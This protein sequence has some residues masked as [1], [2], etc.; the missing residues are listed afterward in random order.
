MFKYREEASL[1]HSLEA[2]SLRRG[3]NPLGY[4]EGREDQAGNM[5]GAEAFG[6]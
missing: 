2:K 6:I 1:K 5:K 4:R 3:R